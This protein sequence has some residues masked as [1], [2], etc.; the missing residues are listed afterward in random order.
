MMNTYVPGSVN[1][2]MLIINTGGSCCYYYSYSVDEELRHGE[3]VVVI[4]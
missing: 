4:V 3:E 2:L 1:L